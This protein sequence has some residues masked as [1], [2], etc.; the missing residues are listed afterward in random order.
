MEGRNPDSRCDLLARE[1]PQCGECQQQ[2]P[3]TDGPTAWGTPHQ[4]VVFPPERTPPQHR[5]EVIVPRGQV[6]MEPS[7]R[8]GNVPLETPAAPRQAV[9]LHGAPGDPLLAAP[10]PGPQRLRL[11]VRPSP[12]LRA[13]RVGTMR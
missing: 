4:V 9:L 8:R 10:Q 12:G 3:G 11:G 1:G 7:D 13:A 5:L 6:R 2:R